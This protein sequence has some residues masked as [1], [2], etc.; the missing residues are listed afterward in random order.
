MIDIK[1]QIPE[2]ITC[3]CCLMHF[4][5]A[6]HAM[7]RILCKESE[8]H[9]A[10]IP[11]LFAPHCFMGSENTHVM[12]WLMT[13]GSGGISSW[14]NLCGISAN[15]IRFT[16]KIYQEK[17]TINDYQPW[18]DKASTPWVKLLYSKINN[19]SVRILVWPTCYEKKLAW[20]LLT[21]L[22][23]QRHLLQ[24]MFYL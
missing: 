5:T 12:M 10:Q 13:I 11:V 7:H 14:C 19:E 23:S 6:I 24:F 21:Q 8:H 4:I 3:D 22:V 15:F 16:S 2:L 1:R 9:L 18:N 17:G 20:L